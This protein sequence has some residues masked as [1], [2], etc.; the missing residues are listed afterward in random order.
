SRHNSWGQPL[1][2]GV[3]DGKRF[4]TATGQLAADPRLEGQVALTEFLVSWNS[5]CARSG[6]G[7]AISNPEGQLQEFK[8]ALASQN[9]LQAMVIMVAAQQGLQERMKS[10]EASQWA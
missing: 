2:C 4:I 1:V 10:Y 5:N 7:E 8:G 6:R 3:A 9:D